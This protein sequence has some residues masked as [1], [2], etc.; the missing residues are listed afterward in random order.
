MVPCGAYF[1]KECAS[2]NT[3]EEMKGKKYE[4][5]TFIIKG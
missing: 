5:D 2:W 1:R 3:A 4:K